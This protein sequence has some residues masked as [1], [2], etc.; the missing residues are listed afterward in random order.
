MQHFCLELS[1]IYIKSLVLLHQY[2]LLNARLVGVKPRMADRLTELQDAVN[3]Q[4]ENL[5]NAIGVIQQLAQP[6]FFGELNLNGRREK[7]WASN[8]EFQALLQNQ[9]QEGKL[10]LL[11]ENL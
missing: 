9:G 4:A 2:Q 8:P 5:G 3:L 1:G 7:E 10:V 11:S 6:S